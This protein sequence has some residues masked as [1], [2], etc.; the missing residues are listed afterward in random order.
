M[1]EAIEGAVDSHADSS[2]A[3]TQMTAHRDRAHACVDMPNSGITIRAKSGSDVKATCTAA[4]LAGACEHTKRRRTMAT[5]CPV[6]CQLCL[7]S[8]IDAASPGIRVRAPNGSVVNATCPLAAL[9][10][11]C[12]HTE[13][14]T[15]HVMA[16]R[17]PVSCQLCPDGLDDVEDI[18][19]HTPPAFLLGAMKCGTTGYANAMIQHPLIQFARQGKEL[20]YFSGWRWD[21]F[22]RARG[23]WAMLPRL[24]SSKM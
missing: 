2:S 19:Q 11:G 1:I 9:A 21:K 22:F 12:E 5:R 14:S 18:D 13:H 3:A 10:G 24:K 4:A 15:R 23:Y 16:M 20:H 7:D 8:C 17:C 6:S